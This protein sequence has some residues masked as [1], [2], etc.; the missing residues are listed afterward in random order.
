MKYIK[1]TLRSDMCVGSGESS[2]NSIDTDVCMN[3]AGIPYIPARRIKGCLR[4]SARELQEKMKYPVATDE[5]VKALFGDAY[6]TEGCL[7]VQDAVIDGAAEITEYLT[8]GRGLDADENAPMEVKAKAHPANVI[9]MFTSVRGQTKLENGVKVDNSLR[10]T[11][12][13]GQYDPFAEGKRLEFF[14]PVYLDSNRE[15]LEKLL[16]ACCKATRHIGMSRNRGLGNVFV[17]YIEQEQPDTKRKFI[18]TNQT[19]DADKTYE[20]TYHVALDEPLVLPAH[21][22]IDTAVAARSVIGCMAGSYLKNGGSAESDDF[23]RMFLNGAVRWTALTPVIDGIVTVP[24]PMMLVKLKNKNG[25]M[26]N[27]LIQNDDEWKRQKPKTM[28]GSYASM[29]GNKYKIA[30]PTVHAVYHHS[31]NHTVQDGISAGTADGRMLYMQESIDAGVVY[32][33]RVFCTGDMVEKVKECIMHANLRFGRSKSAQYANCHLQQMHIDVQ[34]A[35]KVKTQEKELIYVVLSSELMLLKNGVYVTDNESV[36]EAIAKVLHI[37][38]ALPAGQI[39]YCQYRAIGGYQVMWQLQKALVPVVR[40]GSV[41]CFETNADCGELPKHILVGENLQEGM[42]MCTVMTRANMEKV[43]EIERTDI[44]RISTETASDKI[45]AV[46][47]KLLEK[48]AL[49]VIRQFALDLD[50]EKE[51]QKFNKND[52]AKNIPSGRLRKMLAEAEDVSRL[53]AMVGD[54]KESDVSSAKEVSKKVSCENL[55]KAIYTDGK[56][57]ELSYMSIFKQNK[58]LWKEIDKKQDVKNRLESKWKIP[59]EIIIH[60]LHYAK[61]GAR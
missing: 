21:D 3:Q 17:E 2:G 23:R 40:A 26:I 24:T 43:T 59:L 48:A 58:A 19:Y 45:T 34:N 16:D 49:D 15:D 36:R 1:I 8:P 37:P 32:G 25:E 47:N 46:Y 9:D 30:Y 61:G 56:S 28:D 20:V 29:D 10:F 38:A 7:S 6:G 39:D 14:A 57:D 35:E 41:F 22:E 55:I 13:V 42:G 44:N 53:C 51:L 4:Q 52:H 18:E 54:I 5:N 11:R 60:R 33:G 12:V 27:N 50:V 31:L